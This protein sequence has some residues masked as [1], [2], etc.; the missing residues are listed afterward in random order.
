MEEWETWEVFFKKYEHG[1]GYSN[2]IQSRAIWVRNQI[3]DAKQS[4]NLSE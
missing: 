2:N 4:A 3:L 1:L